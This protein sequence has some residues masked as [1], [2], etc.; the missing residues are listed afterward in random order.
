MP[1]C[2]L[3]TSSEVPRDFLRSRR[4]FWRHLVNSIARNYCQR[5]IFQRRFSKLWSASADN[6]TALYI[7]GSCIQTGPA[8]VGLSNNITLLIEYNAWRCKLADSFTASNSLFHSYWIS[9][10]FKRSRR[11]Y[12]TWL[13]WKFSPNVRSLFIKTTASHGYWN[14]HCKHRFTERNNFQ[15][16]I[17]GLEI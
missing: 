14:V 3:N 11:E 6:V 8:T 16:P 10:T 7:H 5:E 4:L 9:S 12:L 2:R 15:H 1:L 17:R 13:P